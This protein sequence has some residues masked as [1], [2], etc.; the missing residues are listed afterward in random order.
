MNKTAY[1]LHATGRYWEGYDVDDW[2][3]VEQEGAAAA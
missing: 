1:E 3:D 2:L